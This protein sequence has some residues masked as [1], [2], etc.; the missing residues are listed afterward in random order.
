MRREEELLTVARS[1]FCRG[2]VCT[3]QWPGSRTHHEALQSPVVRFQK[4]AGHRAHLSGPVPAIRAVHKHTGPFLRNCLKSSIS[5]D[6][7][8]MAI[9]SKNDQ[10][11]VQFCTQ[12]IKKRFPG[13]KRKN[14][15]PNLFL[16][17]LSMHIPIQLGRSQGAV[18]ACHQSIT[19]LPYYPGARSPAS[20]LRTSRL[21]VQMSPSLPSTPLG[22]AR[23]PP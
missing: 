18:W 4:E 7:Q 3:G 13:K 23:L 6:S 21:P 22:P 1:P 5:K 2:T 15:Y 19:S 16:H 20:E 12:R 17:L 9:N 8:R 11:Q 14:Q 10:D